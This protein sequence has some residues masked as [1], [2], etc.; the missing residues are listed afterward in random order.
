MTA[1]LLSVQ[2]RF[3]E[4]ILNGTKTYELRRRFPSLEPGTIVYIYSSSP[5]MAIVG[6]FVSAEIHRSDKD[7]LWVRLS[8][9]LGLAEQEY[10]SYLADLS[11]GVGISTT[12]V[13]RFAKALPLHKIRSE[14]K[15]DA[16]QSFRYI[17]GPAEEWL[18]AW[19][20]V[21]EE[22]SAAPRPKV[23]AHAH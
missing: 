16:P 17:P 20:G 10:Q 14:M 7:D 12:S 1:V 3:A 11:H 23:L 6:S 8:A 5:A 22:A 4:A 19:V 13:R 9:F 21:D 18:K 2:P 15:L